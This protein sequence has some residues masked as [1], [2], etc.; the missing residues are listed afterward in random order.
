MLS[1]G[2][3]IGPYEV[4]SA[5]GAGGMG[6]V[7]RARDT[8]LKRDV[9]IK[10]LPES[11]ATDP[12]RLARFHREAEVLASLNHPNIAAVYGL[13]D[14]PAE[15]GHYMRAIVL[16]LVEGETL[17]D[18]IARGPL[19]L[20]ALLPIAR[21]IADAFEAAHEKG[22][23]HRDL[24]PANVK[25]TPDGTV[26]VLDFGLAVMTQDPKTSNINATHSPTLTLATQA[27]VIM[28]TA[29]YM[30][31]EQASGAI[32]DRR[33]DVWAFGV[34]LWEMLTGKRLFEGETVSHTLAYVLTKE[35]DW[36]A[37]PAN[38]PEAIRRLLRRCLEK[39]RKRRL[40]DFTSARLDIDD[41]SSAPAAKARLD[42][43]TTDA[44]A[45]W[46][47]VLQSGAIASLSVALIIVLLAW[48][49]WR[50]SA[51]PSLV[52]IAVDVGADA[53]L[54][55][56]GAPA[57]NLA[58]TNDGKLLAFV[59]ARRSGGAP[60]LFIRRLDQLEATPLA[61]SENATYPFFSPNGQWI[62]FFADGKLKKIAVSGGA[63]ITLCDAPNGRGGWWGDDGTIVFAANSQ[64]GS[65]LSRVP[66][67]GGNAE[68]LTTPVEG[69]T[70]HR[71]PQVLPGGAVLYTTAATAGNFADGTIVVQSIAQGVRKVLLRGGYFGRYLPSGHLVY[72]HDSTLFAV[73]FDVDRLEVS[74]ERF[75]A[76]EGVA[77]SSG[78]GA[79]Q[80][81]SSPSGTVVYV[82][83]AFDSLESSIGW[84]DS[85][86]QTTTLR[87]MRANWSNP[88][89]SPNGRSLAM[90]IAGAGGNLDVWTYEWAGDQL[91][92]L[93][94]DPG[95]DQKPVWTPDGSR[96]VFSSNRDAKAALNLYWQR[97][98]G[99]GDVQR[100]TESKNNQ[101]ASSWHPSGKFLAF[102]EQTPQ[103]AMD[104]LI[105]PL[106]G[107]EASGWKVGK[108]STFLSTPST[109]QEP[110]FSPDGRWIAYF[111]AEGGRTEVF[112]RPFPGP[113]G[114]Q[115]ISSDGGTFP[116]WSRMKPELFFANSFNNGQ[117]MVAPFATTG[118][119]FH[120]ERPRT[121]SPGRL[122]GRP[123]SR[124]LDVHPDGQRFAIAPAQDPGSGGK[125][126]KLVLVL[127]FF[128]EL[129][130]LSA[131]AR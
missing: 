40:A 115:Q 82:A 101:F 68:R 120:A 28:G 90:D 86:G 109:E 64:P 85:K 76:I 93:T 67:A 24:K 112:V 39:D 107:D 63:T 129:R 108:P 65:G 49:P 35:P 88:Q 123:R 60:Q 4:V 130:R 6:E 122:T 22:I 19:L 13:E 124:A 99:T 14:G 72:V 75:P 110:M 33:A 8:R 98:D 103:A 58:L 91:S 131:T 21:Q 47:H 83:G 62:V 56:G 81:A 111:A 15:A 79:V 43:S 61:G 89:F 114:L 73:P 80:F 59:A 46:R 12:D 25:V 32:A 54:D 57:A 74:G 38:T 102:Y 71:F 41:A 94:F 113:G 5:L 116:M 96:I 125:E 118:N 84:L 11:F 29:A 126:S 9:A 55:L 1:Q 87:S 18:L 70:L 27:G 121:W 78:T 127:N 34:V 77:T 36:T 51:T 7:Y 31:P 16:E 30:S 69:E 44:P 23:I 53:T 50:T 26:K 128:D 48:S 52:R 117:I 45:P 17:A 97:A 104:L 119:S 37:L 95:A 3:R 20:T 10:V 106:E 100:L 2:T 92:R 66:A 105:L 42:L